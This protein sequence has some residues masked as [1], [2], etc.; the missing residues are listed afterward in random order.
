MTR[1]NG[2]GS[3]CWP[4]WASPSRSGGLTPLVHLSGSVV[5]AAAP[6]QAHQAGERLAFGSGWGGA[7][8]GKWTPDGAPPFGRERSARPRRAVDIGLADVAGINVRGQPWGLSSLGVDDDGGVTADA[9]QC[10]GRH[11]LI[12]DG[13]GCDLAGVGVD[14][15]VDEVA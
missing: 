15:E 13:D 12:A 7:G 1:A 2:Q 4:G 5:G 10:F 9:D 11:W 8:L 3:L 6:R 14:L